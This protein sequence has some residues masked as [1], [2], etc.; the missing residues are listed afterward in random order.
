MYQLSQAEIK[1]NLFILKINGNL[2]TYL[3]SLVL[4]SKH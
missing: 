3:A 2:T 4:N 1:L